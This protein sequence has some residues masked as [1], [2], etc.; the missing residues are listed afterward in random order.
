MKGRPP[1]VGRTRCGGLGG[2]RKPC[3]VLRGQR[4]ICVSQEQP[5]HPFTT[6]ICVAAELV[7]AMP[8][9]PAGPSVAPGPPGQ[10]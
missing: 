8:P 7:G 3:L 5:E 9:A 10:I 6:G 2:C 1:V 4:D